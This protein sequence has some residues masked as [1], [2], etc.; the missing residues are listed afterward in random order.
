MNDAGALGAESG[1]SGVLPEGFVWSGRLWGDGRVA[2]GS[3]GQVYFRGG[4]AVF[5][6]G[7]VRTHSL[8]ASESFP[9]TNEIDNR[10]QAEQS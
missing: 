8:P 10:D 4:T 3:R 1:G 2:R 6:S 7:E 9:G 5:C